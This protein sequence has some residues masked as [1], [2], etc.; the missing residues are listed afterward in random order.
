[1]CPIKFLYLSGARLNTCQIRS[2]TGVLCDCKVWILFLC[3]SLISSSS[4]YDQI[5]CF[6]FSFS[7]NGFYSFLQ[8]K[9]FLWRKM[10]KDKS[11]THLPR[12]SNRRNKFFEQFSVCKVSS[13]FENQSCYIYSL[14]IFIEY[15]FSCLSLK[16]GVNSL[17][18][19]IDFQ[20]K[21]S[22]S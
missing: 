19:N 20:K 7:L 17:K 1:M 14:E 11:I 22:C 21:M 16:V 3:K 10:I 2:K 12:E 4:V 5:I 6:T 18:A 8:N 9:I 15:I 13:N